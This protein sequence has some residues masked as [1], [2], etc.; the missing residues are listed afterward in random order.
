MNPDV[1]FIYSAAIP[2]MYMSLPLI[3]MIVIIGINQKFGQIPIRRHAKYALNPP[4]PFKNLSVASF[5]VA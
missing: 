3:L 1:Y 5:R 4:N 2:G